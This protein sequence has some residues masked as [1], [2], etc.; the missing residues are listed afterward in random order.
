[1]LK[2]TSFIKGNVTETNKT[3]LIGSDSSDFFKGQLD[4]VI[5][6]YDKKRTFIKILI[7][8]NNRFVFIIFLFQRRKLIFIGKMPV[9]KTLT[10]N[11]TCKVILIWT[12]TQIVC[13]CFLF[14]F[15]YFFSYPPSLCFIF[16]KLF[17][18][19]C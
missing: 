13:I 12:E 4:E 1:M 15:C 6:Q 3:L 17:S 18:I 16:L 9:Q 19:T 8:C 10:T 14:A 11:N 7:N 2:L 5:F